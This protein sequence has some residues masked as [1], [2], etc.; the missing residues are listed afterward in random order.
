MSSKRDFRLF[1]DLLLFGL[2]IVVLAIA[3]WT[4]IVVLPVAQEIVFLAITFALIVAL[5]LVFSAVILV[6][7]RLRSRVTRLEQLVSH[8]TASVGSGVKTPIQVVTLSNVERRILNRLEDEGGSL[9]QDRLRRVT[10]L[11]KS[12]LSTALSNLE[13]KSIISRKE[14]GRTKLVTLVRKIRR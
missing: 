9:A 6:V 7:M 3:G 5:V 4:W 12:T 8:P 10:G 2:A 1:T 11:S 13:A 14:Y